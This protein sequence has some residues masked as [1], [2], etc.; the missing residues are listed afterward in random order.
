[1][2][3][4]TLRESA[5]LIFSMSLYSLSINFALYLY[6]RH[7]LIA[8]AD[9]K[10]RVAGGVPPEPDGVQTTQ[11]GDIAAPLDTAQAPPPGAAPQGGA[12]PAA[13]DDQPPFRW[14]DLR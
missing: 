14:D 11:A 5:V 10:D 9:Q 6:F 1:M 2:F 7:I 4:A 12:A 8:N 3:F 13:S